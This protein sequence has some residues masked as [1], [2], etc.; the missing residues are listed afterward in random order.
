MTMLSDVFVPAA[1]RP[2][3]LRAIAGWNPVSALA[4][5][6]RQLFGPPEGPAGAWPLEH[7]VAATRA[8][9][10]LLLAVFVPLATARY[11]RPS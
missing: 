8:R 4:A 1:G 7:P 5:A 3:W 11:A 6:S 10:A 9:T 2:A